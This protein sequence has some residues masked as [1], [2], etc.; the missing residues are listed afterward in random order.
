MTRKPLLFLAVLG[1]G[2]GKRLEPPGATLEP[3]ARTTVTELHADGTVLGASVPAASGAAIS[4]AAPVSLATPNKANGPAPGSTDDNLPFTPDGTRVASVAWR[5]WIYTDVGKQ[6]TRYGYLR[7]GALVDARGPAIVNDGCEGGWYRVNPRGFV[8]IGLGASLELNDPVAVASVNRPNRG[9]GSPYLYALSNETPPLLYFKL[10]SK[11]QMNASEGLD[12]SQRAANFRER[13]RAFGKVGKL[14]EL[15]EPPEFLAQG[16]KLE[17]P[18]GVKTTLRYVAHAG[19]ASADSGFAIAK[20]FLWQDRAFGL[21]SELDVIALDRVKLVEPSELH[22]VELL[23]GET[24]PVAFVKDRSVPKYGPDAAGNPVGRG[25]FAYREGLKL[26]NG[27]RRTGGLL[28]M[29]DGT[30]A[31][32]GS[33]RILPARDSY[34]SFA[35]GD[36]KWLDISIKQQSLVAYVGKRPV[37]ATLV[38]TGRAGMGDP[39]TTLSTVRG[40]FMIYQKEVSSTMDGDED[41]SDSFNLRDVPFVQYFHKGYALHGTYW[42]DDFGK[43]R[44]H[45][46]VNLAADDAAWLFEWT[47]PTVPVDWHGVVNKERGTVV[48]IHG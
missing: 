11:A 7:V 4:K 22:G 5:T 2:C 21:T 15:G 47:D 31:P 8:C 19:P 41:R 18:Y 20:T 45:G 27:K 13:M 25:S 42:H 28:E 24:L 3:S 46:C 23:P 36:R 32:E 10:P 14:F 40:T 44:S 9:H 17:K 38:S 34:P 48:Y 35:T 43:V 30:F 26:L 1:L 39:E 6:R 12:V 37:Y 16:Q 33:L 29:R